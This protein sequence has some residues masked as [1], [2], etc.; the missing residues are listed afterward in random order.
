MIGAD[1]ALTMTYALMV[2]VINHIH[3][4]AGI[5]R[6]QVLNDLVGA[7]MMRF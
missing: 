4:S 1:E 5:N 7:V 3:Y 6:L 2:D